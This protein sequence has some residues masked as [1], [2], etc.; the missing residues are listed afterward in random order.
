MLLLM[1][2]AFS[3]GCEH[4][5]ILNNSNSDGVIFITNLNTSDMLCL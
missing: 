4:Y 5:E 1:N 2:T 3:M